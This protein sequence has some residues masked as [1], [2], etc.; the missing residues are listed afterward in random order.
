MFHKDVQKMKS[1]KDWSDEQMKSIKAPSLI[2]N[3][4]NDVGSVEH[5]VEMYRTI[6]IAQLLILPGK[7]GEYIGA[8]EFLDEG[9]WKQHYIADIINNFLGE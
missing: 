5:A 3:G 4:N 2:I 9:K 7:H 1:F 6:P 8:V